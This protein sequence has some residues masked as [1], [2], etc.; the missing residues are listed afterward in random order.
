AVA[1]V[2]GRAA[3]PAALI[4]PRRGAVVAVGVPEG[5]AA[6]VAGPVQLSPPVEGGRGPV[7]ADAGVTAARVVARP[8]GAMPAVIGTGLGV[9]GGG[10]QDQAEGGDQA[11]EQGDGSAHGS[12]STAARYAA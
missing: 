7:G 2:P 1:G 11:G 10:G 12:L 5:V 6:I 4:A 9:R 3:D 8:G